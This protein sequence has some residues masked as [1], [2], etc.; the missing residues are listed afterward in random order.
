MPGKGPT[1]GKGST[2]GKWSA[3]VYAYVH[4][5]A[6]DFYIIVYLPQVFGP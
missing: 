1:L 4:V 5:C 3:T 6:S 2:L